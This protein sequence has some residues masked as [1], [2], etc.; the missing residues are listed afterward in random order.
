MSEENVEFGFEKLRVWRQAVDFAGLIYRLTKLFPRD[1]IF[2]LTSQL[3]RASVSIAAN[4]AEGSSRSSG[5]DRARFF[6][7]AYGSLNEVVTILH[8]AAEQGLVD[9]ERLHHLKSDASDICKMLSGLK[10]SAVAAGG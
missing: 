1:E 4:I 6:E 5:K 10:R 7:I 2:G 8:I 3:R 9:G